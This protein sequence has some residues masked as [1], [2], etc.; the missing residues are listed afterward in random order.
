MIENVVDIK[1]LLKQFNDYVVLKDIN[2]KIKKGD[3]LTLIGFSGSGKTTFLN[4]LGLLDEHYFGT[5]F[6]EGK[7]TKNIKNKNEFRCSKIGYVFQSFYL[8]EYLSVLDNI[9]LP[10]KYA[11]EKPDME[12]IN[13]LIVDLGLKNVLDS[14]ICVLSGGEKQRI[15]IAR[16]LSRKP[17]LLLCDE[18]TGNLDSTNREKVLEILKKQNQNYLTTIIVVTHDEYVFGFGNRK[19]ILE[20]GIINEK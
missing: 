11:N 4:I 1:H 18:P 14:K 17:S 10:F 3:F 2:L 19:C 5:Y 12:Y 7:D 6:F 9:L 8:I 15:A 13:Q 20:S 16:A